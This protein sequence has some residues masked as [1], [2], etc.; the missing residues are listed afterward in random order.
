MASVVECIVHY[1][2]VRDGKISPLRGIIDVEPGTKLSLTS[3]L[4]GAF[5]T[6]IDGGFFTSSPSLAV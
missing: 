5:G 3:F 1:E 2:L 6:V 4:D